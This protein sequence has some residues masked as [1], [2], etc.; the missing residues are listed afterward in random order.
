MKKLIIIFVV[1]IVCCKR[2][3]VGQVSSFEVIGNKP[4]LGSS[5]V[6][7]T[8]STGKKFSCEMYKDISTGDSVFDTESGFIW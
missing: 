3:Y 7:V 5:V 2:E 1:L 4:M 8:T 6:V